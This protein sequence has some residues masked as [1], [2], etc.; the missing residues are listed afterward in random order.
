VSPREL[1]PPEL[2]IDRSLGRKQLAEALR[3]LDLGLT[4]HTMASV[5]GEKAAQE[6]ADEAWL[7]DAGRHG[8]I[9]LMKDDAIRRRPAERD[10]LM[11]AGVCAFCLTNAQLR[12]DEQT[13][14]F[15]NNIHRI[16]QRARTPGPYIYGVYENRLELLWPPR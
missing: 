14:R 11:R 12:G 1:R 15:V 8:W 16:L 10:A 6:L 13:A 7:A 3:Q 2:F 4:V 5:Y 9:V